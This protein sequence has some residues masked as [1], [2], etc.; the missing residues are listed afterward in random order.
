MANASD[1]LETFILQRRAKLNISVVELARKA[2]VTRTT[3]YKLMKGETEQAKLGTILQLANAL[4]VHPLALLRRMLKDYGALS[5]TPG[6][7]LYPCDVTGF[8]QDVTFP[9]NSLVLVGQVFEKIWEIQNLGKVPWIGRRLVCVDEAVNLRIQSGIAPYQPCLLIPAE[10]SVTIPD[11]LPEKCVTLS[12]T[13]TAP[14]YPGTFL[15]YW[16]MVDADGRFCFPEC[17]GLCCQVKV[18]AI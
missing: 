11:T 4:E 1:D 15:S 3:Y 10:C 14:E 17:Q 8:V 12:V 9:D 16:K 5:H 2:G 6:T 13:F 7:T 18:V